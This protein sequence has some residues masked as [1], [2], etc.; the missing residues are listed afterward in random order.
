VLQYCL[1]GHVSIARRTRTFV[2]EA[3]SH[4]PLPSW[5]LTRQTSTSSNVPPR[6]LS[7]EM[8]LALT[9][10]HFCALQTPLVTYA[11]NQM[12]TSPTIRS[13]TLLCCRLSRSQ[14]LERA[15]YGGEKSYGWKTAAV[16]CPP[17]VPFVVIPESERHRATSPTGDNRNTPR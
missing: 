10:I 14:I 12:I 9:R 11:H 2:P 8:T 13:T 1:F 15:L 3:Y 16:S 7:C 5:I 4:S 6:L 17:L